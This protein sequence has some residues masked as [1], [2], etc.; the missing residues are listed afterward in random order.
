MEKPEYTFKCKLL[1]L[2]T[3]TGS[4]ARVAEDLGFEVHTLDI[5]P[6]CK[7]DICADI[8]EFDYKAAFVPGYFD[9]IWASPPCDTFSTARR[10]NIGRTVKGEVM[11]AE[12]LLRDTLNEGV[13]ILRKC[14]E[15]IHF[16]Q[17][18]VYFIE[19]PFTGAM[20]NYIETKPIVYDYCMYGFGYRKR[21]AIWSSCKDL[22][23]NKCDRSHLI[24][25]RH[26]MT[27][28]GTSKT[29]RG[30]GGG[31]SKHARYSIPRDLIVHL[32]QFNP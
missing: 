31:N 25:G 1:D 21:T 17:P 26:A 27:A 30:Q 8:L 15:I 14:Q 16:L 32:L 18:K 19:N 10:S 5:D 3:G 23:G 9:I 6:K 13:P 11:T 4:V 20:K 29:Q 7:P 24:N 22:P 2:F 28:I 12:T